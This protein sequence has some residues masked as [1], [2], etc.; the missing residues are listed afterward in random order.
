MGCLPPLWVQCPQQVTHLSGVP[1][2]RVP[3]SQQGHPSS[4][5]DHMGRSTHRVTASPCSLPDSHLPRAAPAHPQVCQPGV[6]KPALLHGQGTRP[7][8]CT[9]QRWEGSTTQSQSKPV[10]KLQGIMELENCQGWKRPLSSSSP[11]VNHATP[12]CSALRLFLES[13]IQVVF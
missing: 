12:P 3:G 11:V 2:T 4:S 13:H 5:S 1:Q 10:S 9:D 8:G 7:Q 6:H